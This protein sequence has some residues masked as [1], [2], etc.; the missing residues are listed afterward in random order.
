M[1]ADQLSVLGQLTSF[2]A[3]ILPAASQVKGCNGRCVPKTSL[4]TDV[5]TVSSPDTAVSK[6]GR[7]VMKGAITADTWGIVGG[8]NVTTLRA[9]GDAPNNQASLTG[10]NPVRK[11]KVRRQLLRNEHFG[12]SKQPADCR[13]ICRCS[14]VESPLDT[15]PQNL[16]SQPLPALQFDMSGLTLQT[17]CWQSS[18]AS[19]T[20]KLDHDEY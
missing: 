19:S 20:R 16:W 14:P 10:I 7:Q 18:P 17:A 13:L 9:A 1:T 2:L 8:F 5:V 6:D 15:W 4:P 12:S 11:F 3:G